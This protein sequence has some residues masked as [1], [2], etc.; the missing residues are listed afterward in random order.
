[1]TRFLRIYAS[2][3]ILIAQ[4]V[5]A[6][7]LPRDWHLLDPAT[8]KV[9]GLSVERTY[10]ELLKGKPSRTVIV[11]VIDS[12]V[13]PEHEDLRDIM[14]VNP[15]EIAGNGRDD[16]GNGYIDDIHGW[17]FISGPG[18]DVNQDT[19]ELTR[20]YV[21]LHAR[22]GNSDGSG[23]SRKDRNEYQYYLRIK[24]EYE[25]GKGMDD[26]QYQMYRRMYQNLKF[27][28]DTLRAVLG[29]EPYTEAQL[30]EFKTQNPALLFA[31][32]MAAKFLDDAPDGMLSSVL[33]RVREGYD[34]LRNKVEYGYNPAFD[35]RTIV[36]DNYTN[37]LERNYGSPSVKGPD[38]SHGTHVAGIIGAVR[39]N[40]IGMRGIA[41]NVRIMSVRAVPDGDERD[42][43]IANAIYYAVN[44][45]AQIIN[46]SFGKGFSP[47]K[48]VVDEAMRYAAKKG[49]LLVHAA[50]NDGKDVDQTPS[51]PSKSMTTGKFTGA[52]LEIGA[53]SAATDE[54]LP[55]DFSNYGRRTVDVFSPGVDIYSTTPDGGYQNNSGT[56]MASPAAAG[57]AALLMS[58][59]PELSA[60]DVRDIMIQS[61][62]KFD[63][64]E[65]NQPGSGEKTTMDKLCASGGLI[66]A[67]TAVQM[68][69]ARKNTS[70]KR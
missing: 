18:G 25:A 52:W 30:K 50:G 35:P 17:S 64:L 39:T 59:F 23:L 8:D 47:D 53:S 20:E 19:Y 62:R 66:N 60:M 33:A 3:L 36:G 1:M 31:K 56:S 13:D 68:A 41:D 48:P 54:S 43:D 26:Q 32:G 21:R 45:G 10:A 46:M 7:E 2:L 57:V 37:K 12:G 65:V 29:P 51:Y 42:K 22:F 16:D 49:V 14:W 24:S 69:I 70:V 4:S 38:A 27:T 11:A 63:G 15:K 28:L 34:Y 6:Q 61:S 67:Y 40:N 9:Q 55:A 5:A 58:Y 44:N